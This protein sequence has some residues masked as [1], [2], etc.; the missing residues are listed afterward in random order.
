MEH[1]L[2]PLKINAR[3]SVTGFSRDCLRCICLSF[4]KESG[5]ITPHKQE[6]HK[7]KNG[8]V[9]K[10]CRAR[11]AKQWIMPTQPYF[12]PFMHGFMVM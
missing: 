5:A 6:T 7:R 11:L 10:V 4:I 9:R 12:Q 3:C 8:G 1:Q 2:T